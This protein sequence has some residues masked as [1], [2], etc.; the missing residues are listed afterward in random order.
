MF[1]A[2]ALTPVSA[3]GALFVYELR[4]GSRIVSDHA[5]N[6]PGSQLIRRS[7]AA[8]G[9]G[10]LLAHRAVETPVRDP[11]SYDRLIRRTAAAHDVDVFLVKAVVH[12]E[13]GFDPHAVSRVGAS[14]LMQLMPATAKRYGVEDIFDPSQNVAGGVRYLRD[15]LR[16]FKNDVRLAVAAYNAGEGAVQ[17]H[18]GVP[19]YSETRQYVTKVLEFRNRYR[20]RAMAQGKTPKV[21]IAR[22]SAENSR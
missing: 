18:R 1:L 15:L 20:N 9:A 16:L 22:A 21:Q 2:T 12:A 5:L 7:V 10:H 11:A 14:G 3:S 19:P 8:D 13:S 6:E 17:R 4:D